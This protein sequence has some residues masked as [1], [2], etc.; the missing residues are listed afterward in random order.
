MICLVWKNPLTLHTDWCERT[1][2]L[3]VKFLFIIKSTKA[4]VNKKLSNLL[5]TSTRNLSSGGKYTTIYWMESMESHHHSSR[6][7]GNI[8]ILVNGRNTLSAINIHPILSRRYCRVS[9]KMGQN[10]QIPDKL[11]LNWK[12]QLQFTK[13]SGREFKS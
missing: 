2:K 4:Y 12:S 8:R 1:T 10:D 5:I 3:L 7:K 11:P 9:L 6:Q 13:A